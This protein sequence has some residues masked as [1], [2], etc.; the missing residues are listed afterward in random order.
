MFWFLRK[1]KFVVLRRF[2]YLLATVMASACV[3][4]VTAHGESEII[5]RIIAVVEDEAIFQSD[6]EQLVKQYTLQQGTTSLS[7]SDRAMLFQRFLKELI[8]NKLVI[9]QAGR[10][11]VSIPFSEVEEQVSKAIAD[12]TQAL[13]GEEAFKLQLEREGFTIESLKKLYR[14]QIRSRMLVQRVLEIEVQRS[15]P[16]VSD[17]ELR[18]YYREKESQLPK[19]PAVVNLRSIFIGLDSSDKAKIN[20][21]AKIDELHGRLIAGESF[22]ELAKAHS[23][24]P[25]APLGGD[26]GF[27]TPNDLADPAFAEAASKLEVG[28]ISEPVL[29][30]YG[31]HVMQATEKNPDNNEV[32]IRHILVRLSADESD[33]QEIYTKATAIYQ[34]LLDGASFEQLADQHSTDPSASAGGDLGWLR[35][36]DLPEF[37][38]DVLAGMKPGDTSQVLRESAGFRIVKLVERETERPYKYEEVKAELLNLYQNERLE[39][40]YTEYI[41]GLR[42]KFL[43]ELR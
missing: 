36:A 38:Q 21:K 2:F 31:Y 24:D 15:G 33:I 28:E 25:S 35:V 30:A 5:D 9:A 11:D 19:R 3:L 14:E 29:T 10:M 18:E 12:N 40:T 32:R 17:A 26:L 16:E 34:Q 13:G 8:D 42:E 39:T 23:E 27:V 41:N 20:A 37:F 7:E 4:A 1:R 6:V 22:A 43:V